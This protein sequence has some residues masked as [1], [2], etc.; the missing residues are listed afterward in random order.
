MTFRG[1]PPERLVRYG[2]GVVF[3]P[4]AEHEQYEGRLSI[5]YVTPTGVVDL[6]FR[7]LEPH[8]CKEHNHGKYLSMQNAK[9]HLYNV[10]AF[11][12]DLPFIV[13]TEGELD[14]IAVECHTGIPAVAVP[15]ATVW[16]KHRFWRRCFDGYQDVV[17]VADGDA[18][19]REC[20]G[21]I[22]KDIP[23][24]RMV[25]LPDGE[26]SN[27]FIQRHGPDEFMRKIGLGSD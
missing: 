9:P 10:R 23:V 6:R 19:G 22:S 13:I 21:A 15:G 11:S 12:A 25:R 17:V 8:D 3:G 20:A 18:A 4:E 7:C 26:D 27:S 16:G 24:S 14:A 5:P 2:L 1:L